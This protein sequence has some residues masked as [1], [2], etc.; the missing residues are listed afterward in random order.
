VS[1]AY[2]GTDRRVLESFDL[3]LPAGAVVAAGGRERRGQEHAREAALQAV[4]AHRRAD[5]RG[6]RA[7]GPHPSGVVARATGRRVPG[8]LPLRA[9]RPPFRRG[10]RRARD[11]TTSRR[12]RPPSRAREP[13]TWW[14]GCPRGSTPSSG[15]PGPGGVE[16]SFGQWQKIALARGFMRERPLLLVLDEPTAA[17]DAGD[18]TRAVRALRG[19]GAREGRPHA[20]RSRTASRPCAW[21]TSS[22]SSTARAWPRSARTRT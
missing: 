17:L 9:A 10:R 14:P 7:A 13:K 6:R 5:P 8:L 21:P 20:A 15:R 3:D 19:G 4:R 18:R 1:F 11:S 16:V 12:S 2:P 22:S